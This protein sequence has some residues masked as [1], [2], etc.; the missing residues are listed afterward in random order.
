MTAVTSDPATAA[1]TPLVRA[2]A[3]ALLARAFAHPDEAAFRSLQEVADLA[4]EALAQTPLRRLAGLVPAAGRDEREDAFVR[5]FTMGASPD[6]PLFES[7]F[8]AADHLQQTGL[9]AD[10]A[11]FYRAFGVDPAAPGFRPDDLVVELEYMGFLCRKEAHARDHLGAPRTGQVRRAQREFLKDHLARWA[12]PLGRRIAVKAM[13]DSFY[14]AAGEALGDWLTA[15][16]E[17][18][19]AGPIAYADGPAMEWDQPGSYADDLS[20]GEGPDLISLDEIDVM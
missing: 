15:E 19:G 17:A 8:V 5:L 3:Y 7:A 2:A 9:M 4:G 12:I 13:H 18:L 6:C 11:G 1:E 16:C 10:I 20:D 14:F